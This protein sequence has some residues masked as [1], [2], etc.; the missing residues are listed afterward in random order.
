MPIERN[1]MVAQG[2][3]LYFEGIKIL[4]VHIFDKIY[5]ELYKIVYQSLELYKNDRLRA[6]EPLKLV[7]RYFGIVGFS[8]YKLVEMLKT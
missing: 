6:Y 7:I 2:I 1:A 8:K 4:K 5:D 3:K